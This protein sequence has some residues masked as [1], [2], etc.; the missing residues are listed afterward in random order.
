M[1]SNLQIIGYALTGLVS[2]ALA[3]LLVTRRQT[4]AQG[5]ALLIA[6]VM[7]AVWGFGLAY[8]ARYPSS[9]PIGVFVL[10]FLF[11]A[12]WLLFLSVLMS[13][14]ISRSS[15][16]LVR[17]GGLLVA[18]GVL[19][20]GLTSEFFSLEIGAGASDL[21]VPGSLITSIFGLVSLEQIYRNARPQQLASLKYL[22]LSL[23]SIFAYDLVLYSN[24]ILVGEISE[25]V[26]GARGYVVAM[27]IPLLAVAA[28][29]IESWSVGVFVSR[30]I[31]LYTATLF[32]AGMYLTAVGVAG[33]YIRTGGGE[34]GLTAQLI[35]SSAA[36]LLL[37]M[38]LFSERMRRRLRVFINKHFFENRYD[39]REE[40]LRLTDTLTA[41]DQNLPLQKRGLKA[42]AQIVDATAGL[43]WLSAR[44]GEDYKCVAGWNSP[45]VTK[46]ILSDSS[47]VQFLS[48]T[49]WVIERGEYDQDPSRYTELDLTELAV[50]LPPF[51][52]IVPLLHEGGLLGFVS[53][54]E[55]RTTSALNF[56]D[57]DLLKTAG[58]QIAS[59]LAQENATEQL[60]ESR[61]FEAFNRLT[62]YIMHDL[63]NLIAQQSLVVENAQ[64]HKDNPEFIDDAI[65]TIKGSVAR[66][67]RVIE[68]LQQRTVEHPN[69]R[70]EVGKLVMSAVSNCADRE[71]MPRVIIGD[72][73]TWV[74]ADRERLQMALYHAIR[75][76]QDA[77]PADGMVTVEVI[78]NA[79]Q[80]EILVSDTG[81]GMDAEFIRDRLFKPF[82]S[83]KGTAGMGMGAYQIRETLRSAGG[84]VVVVSTPG[85]G[86]QL[87]MLLDI[88]Q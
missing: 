48:R 86:T 50:N 4:Q 71:P 83:T 47:L 80:C 5:I 54:T 22:C 67:R 81:A 64:R 46:T 58:K 44:P 68:H 78:P 28:R 53:L 57:R 49:G 7:S 31:V 72:S 11:D 20:A 37:G 38:F 52:Y 17:F 26:W 21:L 18:M 29:R 33:Y 19:L 12:G 62:A 84:T 39:Y 60:A 65:G 13:G 32:G 70:I 73:R 43:L 25:A 45:V 82:D 34:W 61:Q 59:Y 75:N 6:A 35:F 87:K 55:G 66:M 24:A 16:W 8:D 63:K 10:E 88:E 27:S 42:L 74:R 85:S 77:T 3:M 36:F 30:Q 1:T 2:L 51:E 15:I 23:A 76:A 14:S 79:T 40:W 41:E 69:Q 56:E 9:S